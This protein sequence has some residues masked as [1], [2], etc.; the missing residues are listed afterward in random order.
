LQGRAGLRLCARREAGTEASVFLGER[1]KNNRAT[2]IRGGIALVLIVL[3]AVFGLILTF[4]IADGLKEDY[5]RHRKVQATTAAAALDYQ[6]VQSLTGTGDDTRSPAYKRL[7]SQLVRIRQSDMSIRYVYLMRPQGGRMVFLLDAEDPSSPDYSP[8]GQVYE[9]AKQ[10]EFKVFEGRNKP[11]TQIEGPV[12][13]RWGTWIS[14]SAYVTDGTG[15]PVALLGTDVEVQKA[16]NSF[17]EIRRLGV[18]FD[19][20]AVALLFLVATQYIFWLHNKDRQEVLR[21]E[22]EASASRL[23]TRSCSRRTG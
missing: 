5:F 2:I 16:L 14:A 15:K 4:Q 13:D 12:K 3:L 21:T 7:L 1:M 11:Y 17:N 23:D 8:P 20:L 10:S 9:Q 22:M 19:M 6:E 18:I